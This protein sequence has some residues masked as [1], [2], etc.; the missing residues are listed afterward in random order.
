MREVVVVG[1][2]FHPYGV[3]PDRSIVDLGCTAIHAALSDASMVWEDIETAFCGTVQPQISVGHMVCNEMGLTGLGI[4]NVE[5]ASA[6]GSSAFREAYLSIASGE[7]ESAIAFGVDKLRGQPKLPAQTK[8]KISGGG[9]GLE[10]KLP[11]HRF[12]E[13][14]SHYM[15]EY[16]IT[17]DQM[18]LVSV[19]S[20]YNASLNENA[21]FRK[22]VTLAEV[23]AARMVVE[24]FTVLHCC[25][26]DEGAA[27]VILCSREKAGQFT[28]K[29]TP[30]VCA[31]VATSSP[32]DG[33]RLI[34][35]TRI[36][37]RQAM[38]KAGISPS[39][40][41][42]IELHD[43]FT[44]EEIIYTEAIGLCEVEDIGRFIEKGETSLFGRHP[45]NSS[46]GLISM[47]HPIGPTG[48]GQI[49]EI[50]WQM[51]GEC[52]KR[53][54]P[55]PVNTAM[56]HMVGAGGVCLIHILKK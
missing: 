28:K 40:L 35:L 55:R 25:P 47:G 45:V 20:H 30:R 29:R 31:S 37:A 3:F 26:W 32:P 38:E 51:R 22:P 15:Q 43:A 14:A 44:I 48:V 52:G 36:T 42:L 33:D 56:A 54:I 49:A 13:L 9:N 46:G 7:H 27:A 34:H 2:G 41:D 12:A 1:A 8:E 21:H 19:K 6:S 5:N 23:H 4:V 11:V 39:D 24:P 16:G 53:Q 10:K 17:R 50:L 18:G